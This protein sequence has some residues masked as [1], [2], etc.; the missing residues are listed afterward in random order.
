MKKLSLAVFSVLLVSVIILFLIKSF[1]AP[2][3]ETSSALKL[4]I[5]PLFSIENTSKFVDQ[6]SFIVEVIAPLEID[7][8]ITA[9]YILEQNH[10][11][12]ILVITMDDSYMELHPDT[13]LECYDEGMFDFAMKGDSIFKESGSMIFLIKRNSKSYFFK[14]S[15]Q[16]TY[17]K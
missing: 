8:V 15:K 9:K 12:K 7:G 3:L 14:T 2:V 17:W 11:D 13:Q 4:P 6:K 16:T 1:N 5:N 10:Y